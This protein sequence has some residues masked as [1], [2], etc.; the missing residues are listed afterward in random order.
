MRTLVFLLVLANLLFFTYD[1]GYFGQPD[2]PDAGRAQQQLNPERIQIMARGEPPAALGPE[3]EGAVVAESFAVPGEEPGP[4]E[5]TSLPE[6]AAP[7]EKS[8][9]PDVCVV[10]NDLSVPETKR[11]MALLSD[12]FGD[13][14][15]ERRTLPSESSGWWVYI[16][17]LPNKADAERKVAEL[18]RL[19]VTDYFIVQEAGPNR[20][21][22]SLGVFSSETSASEHLAGLKAKGLKNVKAGPRLSKPGRQVIEAH[23]A[24]ARQPALVAAAAA[25]LPETAAQACTGRP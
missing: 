2:N 1:E 18:R 25:A 13:F 19:G 22:V 4:A 10:W 14:K 16:P 8:A 21:A 24:T 20:F 11:L 12:K 15:L 23:G 5:K 7:T 9:L 17:P 3:K 6:R